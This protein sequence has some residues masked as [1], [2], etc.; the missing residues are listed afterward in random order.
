MAAVA[1]AVLGVAVTSH[2]E[3]N[4]TLSLGGDFI[5]E[6]RE[7][8]DN[9]FLGGVTLDFVFHQEQNLAYAI[10]IGPSYSSLRRTDFSGPGQD[11]EWRLT[12]YAVGIRMYKHN[13][14]NPNATYVGAGVAFTQL[15][16]K[17][18]GNGIDGSDTSLAGYVRVGSFSKLGGDM[19]LGIDVRYRFSTEY[20]FN[21]ASGTFKHAMDGWQTVLTLGWTW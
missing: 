15:E 2:A 8:V 9:G 3:G 11:L 16:L 6:H 20:E 5:A 7:G 4:L 17:D 21:D 14:E 18:P 12:D 10:E 19:S 13:P 1:L